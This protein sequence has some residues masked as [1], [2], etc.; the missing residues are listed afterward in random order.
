VSTNVR[1]LASPWTANHAFA[2]DA[3]EVHEALATS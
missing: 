3:K 1:R 2:H